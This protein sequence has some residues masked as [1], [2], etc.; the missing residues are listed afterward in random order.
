KT[1]DIDVAACHRRRARC[2]RCP[3]RGLPQDIELAHIRRSDRVLEGIE[4]VVPRVPSVKLGPVGAHREWLL[5]AGICAA[6][7]GGN[8]VGVRLRLPW[9][10]DSGAY[11]AGAAGN[12]E[13]EIGGIEI[14]VDG[15][16]GAVAGA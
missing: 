7:N 8:P 16:I 12:D 10:P 2:S 9:N 13:T 5:G 4:A 3:G 6:L 1:T 15:S 11:V 14:D